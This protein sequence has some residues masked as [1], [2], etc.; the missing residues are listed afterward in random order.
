MALLN[1]IEEPIRQ[2]REALRLYIQRTDASAS[3]T[4][5]INTNTPSH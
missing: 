3:Q 5:W 2:S 4:P 1:Y